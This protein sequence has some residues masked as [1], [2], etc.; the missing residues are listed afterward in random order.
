MTSKRELKSHPLSMIFPLP[1]DEEIAAMGEDVWVNDLLEPITLY[2]G[3]ILDGRSRQLG[4]DRR[5]KKKRHELRYENYKGKD[6]LG[7]VISKNLRRRHLSESQRA[8]VAARISNL[9]RGRPLRRTNVTRVTISQDDAGRTTGVSR[10]SVN[11]AKKVLEKG[12]KKLQQAVERGEVPVSEAANLAEEDQRTQERIMSIIEKGEAPNVRGA[13][14]VLEGEAALAEW[15]ETELPD[16]ELEAAAKEVQSGKLSSLEDLR[17]PELK[18]RFRCILYNPPWD[19]WWKGLFRQTDDPLQRDAALRELCGIPISHLGHPDGYV[20]WAW[21]P[22][23][24]IREGEVSTFLYEWGVT[25]ATE[26]VWPK[27][28]PS[29]ADRGSRGV[30]CSEVLVLAVSERG[31]TRLHPEVKQEFLTTDA[32]SSG[33]RPEESYQNMQRFSRDPRIELYGTHP[34]KGWTTWA[35]EMD[36]RVGSVRPPQAEEPVVSS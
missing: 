15:E 26:Y 28:R 13:R 7:F 36:R 12:I 1:S 14:K 17:T 8:M 2:Q 5:P 20:V 25:W 9:R 10:M 21:F 31:T 3:K 6:P 16:D 27:K 19:L 34:R 35:P 30:A 23:P 29:K 18:G 33:N 4:Q 24:M 22:W 11:R 32:G